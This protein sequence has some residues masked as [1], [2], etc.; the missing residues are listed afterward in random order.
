[1]EVMDKALYVFNTY[2]FNFISEVAKVNKAVDHELS[3]LQRAKH[4]DSTK[5]LIRFTRSLSPE[6]MDALTKTDVITDIV[7]TPCIEKMC[8]LKSSKGSVRLEVSDLLKDVAGTEER[9]SWTCYLLLLALF[10]HVYR[11]AKAVQDADSDS[12]SETEEDCDVSMLFDHVIAAIKSM[13][14]GEEAPTA[15]ADDD[16][17]VRD[18][19]H[20]ISKTLAARKLAAPDLETAQ[21]EDA[22]SSPLPSFL[23]GADDALLNTK[24]G[25]VA[26]EI[27]EELDLSALQGIEKPEDILKVG[28][29][30]EKNILGNLISKIGQKVHHKISTGEL[31]HEDLMSET[32]G[33]LNM[34]NTSGGASAGGGGAGGM[35]GLGNLFNS[36]MFQEV[37]KNFG[38]GNGAKVGINHSKVRTEMTRDRL[39]KKM[40]ARRSKP[41]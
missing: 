4:M 13:Q 18:L 25:S 34:M 14:A 31:R 27:C 21:D 35:A 26:K 22:R 9:R 11:L 2:F 7:K 39:R 41:L 40:E 20:Q 8:F 16:G 1:M 29:G 36:P 24:I 10:A 6:V 37:M 17:V 12:D 30:G 15:I 32:L 23:N 28:F 3:V 5:H 33:M 38:G 19:L